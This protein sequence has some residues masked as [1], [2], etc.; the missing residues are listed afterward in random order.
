M[1]IESLRKK[2]HLS[3]S[4]INDYMECGLLYKL[5]RI[6]RRV[7]EEKAEALL[8]GTTIHKTLAEFHQEKLSGETL[9]LAALESLFEKHWR[10]ANEK[11]TIRYGKGKNPEVLL[12]DGVQLIGA[13]YEK[14]PPSF[15][16]L[17]I[18]EPFRFM[19]GGIPII[20]VFDLIEEDESGT[21]IVTDWKTSGKAY[22]TREVDTNFQMTLYH[23]AVQAIGYGGREILLRFDCLIKTMKPRFEQYYTTRNEMDGRRAVKKIQKVWEGIQKGVFIPNDLSWK[24][25]NCSY[26]TFCEEW[27]QN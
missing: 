5:S 21:L 25:K 7:P 10:E 27:F 13:Y 22:S 20:G 17:A 16:I 11:N 12:K 8:F 19:A 24:C 14:Q 15:K 26:K 6:D 18:E 3:A 1:D 4:S 23:M 2:P 9:S